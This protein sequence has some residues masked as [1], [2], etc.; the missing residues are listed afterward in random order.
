[1]PNSYS[2]GAHFED[3]IQGRYVVGGSRPQAR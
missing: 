3:L 2:L 1:M